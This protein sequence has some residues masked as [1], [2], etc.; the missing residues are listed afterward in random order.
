MDQMW[1]SNVPVDKTDDEIFALLGR[2]KA[3]AVATA[4]T[5]IEAAK[6][7][8]EKFSGTNGTHNPPYQ[9][10]TQAPPPGGNPVCPVC[11]KATTE[12]AKSYQCVNSRPYKKG[13]GTWAN[14]GCSG[15]VK[16]G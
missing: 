6:P 11:G 16:K 8:N 4:D 1:F 2:M 9:A 13:D 15:Y 14:D 5:M 3:T 12:K 7:Y 10:N